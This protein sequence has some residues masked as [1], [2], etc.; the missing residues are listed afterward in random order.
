MRR[1]S[2]Q[3]FGKLEEEEHVSELEPCRELSEVLD[4]RMGASTSQ[5][6]V[7]VLRTNDTNID[8][9]T[10]VTHSNVT[11]LHNATHGLTPQYCPLEKPR[12]LS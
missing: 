6:G 3:G 9:E 5:M 4:K 11:N 8:T 10:P 1:I 2:G 7:L 12:S